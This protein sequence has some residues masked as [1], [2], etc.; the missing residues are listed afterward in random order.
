MSEAHDRHLRRAFALAHEA[1]LAGNHP[2]GAVL[3]GTDG[4]VLAEARNTVLTARD[5]TG[6]AETNLLREAGRRYAEAVLA[7]ATL[8][9]SA[10]PCPMCAG[11]IYWSGVACLVY[12]LP[13]VR[14]AEIGGDAADQILLPARDVL[15]RGQRTVRVVGP[16]LVV[17]AE[18]PF[19]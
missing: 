15:A 14:L 18:A 11:A 9:A 13:T 10:E 6:H 7:G 1:A 8:Y 3:V 19:R 4:S 16:L 5:V 2:F 17:E 12:G